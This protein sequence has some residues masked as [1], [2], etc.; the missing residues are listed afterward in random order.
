MVRALLYLR[1]M[2][3]VNGLRSRLLRLR[4]PKYLAGAVVGVGYFYLVLF[5]HSPSHPPTGAHGPAA[6]TALTPELLAI[7]ASFGAL[8]FLLL[9]ALSWLVPSQRAGLTFS[10]AEIAF[11][12]P[13][14]LTRRSLIHYKLLSSQ[15]TIL[16]SA[17]L[18]TL[19]SRHGIFANGNAV[20]HAIGWWFI[21]AILNL[22]TV[23]SSF[24]ITRLLD[25][26]VTPLRRCLL[27]LGG[28][29][30]VVGGTL[31]WVWHDLPRATPADL[32]SF[33][34][35]VTWLGH[36]VATP[37][38]SWLLFP[39]KLVLGP[40][41]ANDLP[42]FFLALGPAGAIFALH[43]L[44]IF[45]SEASFEE[46]VIAKAEKRA[47]RLAAIQAGKGLA[48]SPATARADPFRLAATG[49][50]EF[51]FLWKNLLGTH[52]LLRL[53]TFFIAA[54]LICLLC[55][56]FAV[57]P[58]Q[59]EKLLGVSFFAFFAGGATLFVG[60]QLA[61]QDLRDDLP[62]TDLLKTYPLRG[63]QLVLG[64][65]LTPVAL[66]S[67][68]LW[69]VLLTLALSLHG[70]K[71]DAWLTT[72]LRLELVFCLGLVAP[73]VCTLQLLVPNAATLLFPAW[74]QSMRNRA[75]RGIE[76]VGQR[77]IFVAGQLL[78][79][80]VALLPAALLAGLLIFASQ[81]L[82]GIA[83]AVFLATCAVAV[84]LVGEIWLGLWWLGQ[85]FERFDLSSELRP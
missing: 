20:T 44:W 33:D 28:L 65:L 63:W 37:G 67:A 78:I 7:Y 1:L 16:F 39:A 80:L 60:P 23:G 12:F 36:V 32:Q 75:E 66:L 49:R 71:L 68:V 10:E 22:H 52:P 53:R 15:V 76:V 74:M 18:I 17:L 69:L 19:L 14:P 70:A 64:E 73:L 6:F 77:I 9:I 58:G 46:T 82:I 26:G 2:S 57:R 4:Q 35:I 13:A 43:Y 34:T 51:A 50:P 11:L 5:R 30:L 81:W 38:L 55:T 42:G 45:R 47:A 56:W 48:S 41:L 25:R 21:L 27:I 84:V 62:N 3:L 85:R 8:I 79:V 83:A 40:F 54:G 29:T 24:T 59:G 61:R 72:S 31:G